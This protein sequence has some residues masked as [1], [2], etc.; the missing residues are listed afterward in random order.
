MTQDF[1]ENV[2]WFMAVKGMVSKAWP[3]LNTALYSLRVVETDLRDPSGYPT[4]GVDAY[5]RLYVN[6]E[7]QE[8]WSVSQGAVVLYHELWHVLR[9]HSD[10]CAEGNRH[11]LVW[12]MAA[13]C[14]INR[15]RL[16]YNLSWPEDILTY[17][18]LNLPP[19]G[20]AEDYYELLMQQ[21][22]QQCPV[23]GQKGQKQK[24][25]DEG[26]DQQGKGQGQEGCTCDGDG[27]LEDHVGHGGCGSGA[28]GQQRPHEENAPNPG[29][30]SQGI[31]KEE[32][33]RISYETAVAVRREMQHKNSERGD[34]PGF[35]QRW[36]DIVMQG[37]QVDWRK[38]FRNKVKRAIAY[39]SGKGDYTYT[40]RSRRQHAVPNIIL[41]GQRK[42]VIRVGMVIDTSGSMNEA[43]LTAIMNELRGI[44]GYGETQGIYVLSVDAAVHWQGFV[45]N[46][47][48]VQ[49]KGGGGT[50]MGVGI[51]EAQRVKPALSILIVCTDTYTPW[52]EYAPEM[53]T[54][55]VSTNQNG[56]CPDWCDYLYIDPAKL[57][58]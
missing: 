47:N 18:N 35:I 15:G 20:L 19:E 24:Q 36:A 37:P 23:H 41:P 1:G 54:I 45:T 3:Y 25:Q 5:F 38:V 12:N 52:P 22:K 55:V 8:R 26:Q 31:S 2:T 46:I 58:K 6:P 13:D 28:H 17:N 21:Q 33:K 27:E 34:V 43:E 50:D 11:P 57:V 53:K 30:R 51:Q 56:K 16:P 39:Q 4:M 42:P 7:C 44:L 40:R 9:E 10:R 48:Q 29:D 32:A 49:L 14:E